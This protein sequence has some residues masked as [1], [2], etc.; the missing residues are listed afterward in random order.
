MKN[1]VL[2]GSMKVV[3][4]II[5]V[6]EELEKKGFNILLPKECMEGLPKKIASRAHFDRIVDKENEIV[7]IVNDTKN[8]RKPG[9]MPFMH[10][11]GKGK[12]S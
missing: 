12:G 7:L 9:G 4:K 11:L 10:L 2:C 5:E 6:G 8:G 1:V 3:N